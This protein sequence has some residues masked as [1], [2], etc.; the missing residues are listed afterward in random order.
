MNKS[1]RFMIARAIQSELDWV[2]FENCGYAAEAVWIAIIKSEDATRWYNCPRCDAGYPDQE[3][4][5]EESEE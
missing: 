2:S 5:C 1:I 4:V 3:C